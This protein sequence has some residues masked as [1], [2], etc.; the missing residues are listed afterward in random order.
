MCTRTS[1][2]QCMWCR[3]RAMGSISCLMES[4]ACTAAVREETSGRRSQKVCRRKTVTLTCCATR[5][6]W[7]RSTNAASISARPADR[8]TPPPM[9]ETTGRPSSVIFRRFFL[10]RSR[11]CHDS[12]RTPV[13]PTRAG[14][15]SRRRGAGGRG[16]GHAAR[17]PRRAR[18]ALSHV[19]R[20]D[21]GSCYARA[22]CVLANLRLLGGSFTRAAGRAST[23]RRRVGGRAAAHH[24]GDCRRVRA[25][26]LRRA[27]TLQ[28][29]RK[30]FCRLVVFQLEGNQ[31]ERFMQSD[32]GAVAVSNRGLW[33]G[34]ILSGLVV[35]FLIPDGIIKFIKPAPVVD[36]FARLGLPLSSS[37]TLGIIL[38]TC[39]VLY[40]IPRTSVLG[41]I[42]L[43]AYLGGAVATHLRVGDPL[44]SHTLF[45]TYLGIM[46]WLG[47]YLREE[48]LRAL[49]P[50]GS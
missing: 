37:V 23:R 13:A 6:P 40:A 24:R 26:P 33:A 34:R 1:R 42:L 46:L 12:S 25:I 22:P 11:R 36:A 45:P 21:P 15:C 28:H 2:R 7:T 48:R 4:C 17:G 5:W 8:C 20:H 38:L 9:P 32:S 27:G 3:S 14:A 30:R 18:S 39:T 41:A 16:P 49:I 43:T 44:F 19:A 10:W 35:L 47:L 31:E 29:Q 50:L